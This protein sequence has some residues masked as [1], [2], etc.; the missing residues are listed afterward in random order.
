MS[1]RIILRLS[2]WAL[3]S[4]TLCG[5]LC[6]GRSLTLVH[7]NDLH[8]HLQGFGPELDYTPLT[9]KD[10]QT[11]G[12]VARIG[13]LIK[14]IRSS[15]SNPVLVVDAGDFTMGTLFHTISRELGAELRLLKAIGYDAVTLG[16]HEFDLKPS[17]LAAILRA[18]RFWGPMPRVLAANVVFDDSDPAD[19]ELQKAFGEIGVVPSEV[20]DLQGVRVGLFGL[21]GRRAAQ[22]APFARPVRFADPAEAAALQVRRLR[23]KEGVDLVVCLAHLGIS[24]QGKGESEELARKVP[25]IDVIVDGH[26]HTLLEKPIL[27]GKT[28]IVQAGS[29]GRHVGVLDLI[30]DGARVQQ[31]KY[32]L[33]T[34]DDSTP[35]DPDLQ[36]QVEVLKREVEERFLS[37]RGLK[38]H[39]ALAKVDFP[40]HD[41]P[42]GDSNLGDLVSD[43]IR[44][45]LDRYGADQGSK[46]RKTDFAVESGG[47]LRDSILPGRRGVLALCDLF[48]AFPL[49]FGPDGEL[50]YPLLALYLTA[51]EIKKALEVHATVAPMKGSD[52]KLR[53]SGLRFSHNPNRV[54]F[55]RVIQVWIEGPDGNL[56]PLDTSSK[57]STLYRV[58]VNL[59]NAS[60]LKIIGGFTYGILDIK[61]K[62]SLG[63]PLL[64][65]KEALV[66]RDPSVPGVQ[67]LKEW[68]ALV[69]FLKHFPD[70]DGDGLA[71]VPSRYA[72]PQRREASFPSWNPTLLFRNAGWASWAALGVLLGAGALL[73][74]FLVK[75]SRLI[76]GLQRRK[77]RGPKFSKAC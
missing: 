47:L 29:Y 20:V 52:Y 62:D 14:G 23:E 36:A 44:W 6:F 65:L 34:V 71:D 67:E 51:S 33:L 25:G 35:G 28:L 73:V 63:R 8:S 68:E 74:V 45:A 10:D 11:L 12:G 66:D 21:M 16:N 37:K 27:V 49:G 39:E 13:A 32:E 60:F 15:R 43:A 40:L 22:V 19:D 1:F 61:P 17:G 18:A 38:Y 50:G 53:V 31:T 76:P 48:R 5:S 54:P 56:T 9:P 2:L 57:N 55:D 77:K 46:S 3:F 4:F 41:Q 69:E 42:M 59:Y 58:G 64:D 75:A 7:T 72:S 26:T 70:A 30:L 24:E